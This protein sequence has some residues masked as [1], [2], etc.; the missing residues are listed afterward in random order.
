MK[1]FIIDTLTG[2]FAIDEATNIVNFIDFENNVEEI[3]EFY[4]K[5][6]ED[7]LIE[8][9]KNFINQ[10][11][12]SGYKDFIFDNEKL[13]LLSS[14][15][16]IQSTISKNSLDFKYFR[17]DLKNHLNKIGIHLDPFV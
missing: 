7:I 15:L 1:C 2:I 11:S 12:Q 3:I 14:Q 10:L 17:L 5:I 9:Y 8:K 16:G 6:E 4:K 13:A